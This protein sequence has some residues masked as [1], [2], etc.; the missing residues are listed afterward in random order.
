MTTEDTEGTEDTAD[1]I[2][3][4]TSPE[5]CFSPCLFLL[6]LSVPSVSSVVILSLLGRLRLR[7]A[8]KSVVKNL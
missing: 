3:K 7:R 6:F 4:E 1:L 2:R 8:G 5:P